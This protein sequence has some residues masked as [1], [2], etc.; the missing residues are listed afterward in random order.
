VTNDHDVHINNIE[1]SILQR[2]LCIERNSTYAQIYGAVV[3]LCSNCFVVAVQTWS[4]TRRCQN[5]RSTMR[6]F[7]HVQ[8]RSPK[9][10]IQN[11]FYYLFK[12]VSNLLEQ[13]T[14]LF[15]Q[16]AKITFL[17]VL[18]VAPYVT[19]QWY[20]KLCRCTGTVRRATHKPTKYSTSK[21]LQ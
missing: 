11:V 3:F 21:S 14:K 16:R 10:D 18:S 15:E 4:V 2:Y 19:T 1:N 7:Y 17:H 8:L 5:Y 13:I 20:K 9:E 6:S 12:Q